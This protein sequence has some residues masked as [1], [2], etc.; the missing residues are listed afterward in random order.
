MEFSLDSWFPG[1]YNKTGNLNLVRQVTLISLN[2]DE[3]C[4]FIDSNSSKNTRLMIKP[5]NQL[6]VV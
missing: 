4:N 3:I 2:L 1:I 5:L 6:F